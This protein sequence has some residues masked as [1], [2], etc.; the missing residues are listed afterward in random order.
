MYK[1]KFA[2]LFLKKTDKILL[3]N[4]I[5]L[6][7]IIIVI[8]IALLIFI[9]I[10]TYNNMIDKRL[11]TF[12]NKQL[13]KLPTKLKPI[14]SCNK[15]RNYR[16]VDYYIASSYNTASIGT[17]HYD[18]V[19]TDAVRNTL[20]QGAR[21]IQLSVCS[22][23]INI[24]DV[25]DE[26]LIGTSLKEDSRI[27]SLNT[28]LLKDV[29]EI[30]N[31]Y[32]F[33]VKA[34]KGYKPI[35]YPLIIDLSINTQ[36]I[37]VLNKT[38]NYINEI[39]GD[40][41]LKRDKYIKF[42]I[43]FEYLCN[44]TNKVILWVN[45]KILPET[46]LN[47]IN[48]PKNLLLQ[49]LYISQLTNSVLNLS[50]LEQYLN[51]IS[52]IN[53][54]E[55]YKNTDIFAKIIANIKSNPKSI[56]NLNDIKKTINLKFN[57]NGIINKLDLENKLIFF[58]TI[59]MSIIEPNADQIY[60]E[61]YDFRLP[62]STGCQIIAMGYQSDNNNLK[63]YKQIFKESSFIL[64]SSNSRLPDTDQ[65]ES[66][67]LL[68]K[69][70]IVK[71]HVNPINYYLP[72]Y[73][74]NYALFYLQEITSSE[75]KYAYIK[76][77]NLL[78]YKDNI[79]SNDN[80]FLLKKTEI[81]GI[82]AFYIL[83]INN[84]NFCLTIKDNYTS[85]LHDNLEF[86]IINKKRKQYQTFIIEK[87][88]KT[89]NQYSINNQVGISIRS[90][91]STDH[92]FYLT[93]YKNK[94]T[95]KQ[96]STVKPALMTFNSEIKPAKFISE[97]TN[98]LYGKVKVFND[99]FVG[100][101]NNNNGSKIEFIYNKSENSKN[102]SN[103]NSN[104]IFIFMKYNGNNICK[105][106]NKLKLTKQKQGCKMLIINENN[107]YFLK[108]GNKYLV[109]TK[110]GILEFKEDQPIIQEEKRDNKGNIIQHKRYGPS[111]GSEKYYTIKSTIKL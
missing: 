52:R 19:S 58:N 98:I 88:L 17:R 94:I 71:Q 62:F 29:F 93:T 81:N 32:A 23:N 40:K 9:V 76:N 60:I 106:D 80:Y 13:Q 21:Y 83:D 33:K 49:K 35:N 91:L 10:I 38:A 103:N 79:L 57:E 87:P 90:V 109:A 100:I 7:I 68:E 99:G 4:N 102:N 25:N 67:D 53:I 101:S 5:N 36:N 69:Y 55:I 48:I 86:N 61:N 54:K 12:N 14:K 20:L 96:I 22:L 18:Y 11:K 6:D 77:N 95:L 65:L 1:N 15:K 45:G 84:H 66:I 30:I 31:A 63:K 73:E 105:S 108:S 72:F 24:N 41:L 85:N 97:L 78:K 2:E 111:L 46:K 107:N 92:P 37:H 34:E 27:T 28:I 16:L 110:D 3:S 47:N 64:K 50:E 44:L 43:Q 42:P 26:P 39:L 75:Y 82:D 104:E 56:N 51:S 74:Y 89:D 59:G 8:I 70:N